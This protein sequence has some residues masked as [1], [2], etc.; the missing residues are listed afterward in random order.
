MSCA[1]TTY[2]CS[3]VN[4]DTFRRR[5][6]EGR[7]ARAQASSIRFSGLGRWWAQRSQLHT[8]LELDDRLL[9]DVGISRAEAIRANRN[10]IW[11]WCASLWTNRITHLAMACMAV[12]AAIGP[13]K[14]AQKQSPSAKPVSRRR[15]TSSSS[16]AQEVACRA[17]GRLCRMQRL[18]AVSR[19][20]R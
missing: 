16:C 13:T 6:P 2:S 8:L 19:C 9:D 4:L 11:L 1:G 5:D 10:A 12:S 15:R 20:S 3:S 17:S 7:G 18:L 14:D